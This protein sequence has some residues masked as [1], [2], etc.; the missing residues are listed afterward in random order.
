A[1]A[2]TFAGSGVHAESPPLKKLPARHSGQC[3]VVDVKEFGESAPPPRPPRCRRVAPG[4]PTDTVVA[5]RRW[6][7]RD[8]RRAF[9]PYANDARLREGVFEKPVWAQ[10]NPRNALVPA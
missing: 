10:A 4:L 8:L 6:D 7:T 1:H 3:G 9:A 2:V 5:A